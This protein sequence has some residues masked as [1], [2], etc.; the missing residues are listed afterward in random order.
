MPLMQLGLLRTEAFSSRYTIENS[1]AFTDAASAVVFSGDS[2]FVVGRQLETGENVTAK[3]VRMDAVSGKVLW[4]RSISGTATGSNTAVAAFSNGDVAVVFAA[5][6]NAEVMRVAPDASIVWQRV[7]NPTPTVF[8]ETSNWIAIDG[9]D[10]VYLLLPDDTSQSVNY[11]KLLGATGLTSWNRKYESTAVTHNALSCAVTPAGK[12]IIGV[13]KGS[14]DHLLLLINTDGTI[15]TASLV[16][17]AGSDLNVRGKG[18]QGITV[19]LDGNFYVAWGWNSGAR[20]TKLNSSF[21]VQWTRE[22]NGIEEAFA[23]TTT[24]VEDVIIIRGAEDVGA[25]D[26]AWFGSVDGSGTALQQRYVSGSGSRET[27]SNIAN[28]T[29][30]FFVV[31]GSSAGQDAGNVL[32]MSP[33]FSNAVS[34]NNV[35]LIAASETQNSPVVPLVDDGGTGSVQAVSNTAGSRTLITETFTTNLLT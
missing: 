13:I 28:I 8:P 24:G 3:I 34:G 4:A 16:N 30:S 2:L 26:R 11:M 6:G 9:S 25:D 15:D 35:T 18:A 7:L 17:D 32:K 1:S 20:L 31:C 12:M 5:G 19:G 33:D 10:D 29:A 21:A 14:D 23:V 27:I 22:W